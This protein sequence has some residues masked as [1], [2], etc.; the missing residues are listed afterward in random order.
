M[1]KRCKYCYKELDSLVP[2]KCNHCGEYFCAD[3]RLPENH[4]C[5]NFYSPQWGKKEYIDR[6][7]VPSNMSLRDWLQQEQKTV[8]VENGPKQHIKKRI[9]IRRNSNSRT[10]SFSLILIILL[11]LSAIVGCYLLNN[12]KKGIQQDIEMLSDELNETKKAIYIS[13]Q[14]LN[15]LESNVVKYQKYLDENKTLLADIIEGDEYE[16]HNPLFSE[17]LDFINRDGSADEIITIENAKRK[18]I[19]CAFVEA[20]AFSGMYP[21]IGFDTIDQGMV[22]FEPNTD[23][24]VFPE[25]GKSY[26]SC[27]EDEP[28][29]SLTI[30]TISQILIFW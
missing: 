6:G 29:Y 9:V 23:Y 10:M 27:V 11:G 30:D 28:Y 14:N 3:H 18:G 12:Y 26:V 15:Y 13:N 24:R 16:L 2:W 21:L 22:Y 19:R 8:K 1:K 4:N 25:I 20:L 7:T 5:Q 17:A